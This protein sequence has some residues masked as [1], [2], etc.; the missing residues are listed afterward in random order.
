MILIR[1]GNLFSPEKKSINDILIGNE[2]I[3]RI[4]KNIDIDSKY[5][6]KTIDASGK[7]IIPGLI[8]PHV[9]I[10]GGG[11]ESSFKSRVP[12]IMLSELTSAG[13]TTVIGLLGTDGTSRSIENLISKAKALK[14]EGLSCYLITGSYEYP[15]VTLTENIRKD[16]MFIDEIIGGKAAVSDHRS[17]EITDNELMRLASDIRVANMLSGK[18][19]G[20]V[21]H[22]GN[23]KDY[24]EKIYRIIKNSEIPASVF[25]P[26]HVNRTHE[27]LNNSLQLTKL[28]GFIDLTCGV[29]NELSPSKII[30]REINNKNINLENIT[31][32]SDGYGSWSNYDK[33]GNII[34]MGVSKVDTLFSEFRK[35]V[36]DEGIDI[37]T[38]LS[39]LTTNS[40]KSLGLYPQKGII[41]EK[42]D[43][44][45][46]IIDKDFEIDTV[47][48]NGQTM[49]EEKNVLIRGTYE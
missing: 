4:D 29:D 3:L 14:E 40:S 31:F 20:L 24:L 19:G 12:E 5:L 49:I 11:G 6:E 10:T 36:V 2:K 30:S 27:L 37:T 1:N 42:S 45:I 41:K 39:F 23:G 26:T 16:I 35:L 38:A 17:S 18:K 13:I 21:L 9:H 46:L 33:N 48:A 32:S 47:I 25:K 8:D 15:T 28:G 22:V 7:M 43:A 44:D 34:E